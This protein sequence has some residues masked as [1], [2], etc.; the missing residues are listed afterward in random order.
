MKVQ[1]I[2]ILSKP[3][4]QTADAICF[5]SNGITKKDGRLVMGAGV[6]KAFRDTFS[7]L[8]Q[9]AGTAVKEYGNICQIVRDTFYLGNKL[10]IVAFPTKGHWRYPSRVDLI[11]QSMFK[12]IDMTNQ[13]GWKTVYLPAPGVNNGGLSWPDMIKPLLEKK[14]DDRF[15]ITFLPRKNK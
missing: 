3:V 5:T 11:K 12:L 4:L 7:D 10:S 2:N 14:L 8:D 13:Y 6:A 1:H 9:E 15:I